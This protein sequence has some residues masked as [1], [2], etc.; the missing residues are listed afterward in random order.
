MVN[1]VSKEGLA[2]KFA[3]RHVNFLISQLNFQRHF[4]TLLLH[5]S[6]GRQTYT[7]HYRLLIQQL[8]W[9]KSTPTR[10]FNVFVTFVVCDEMSTLKIQVFWDKRCVVWRVVSDVS[11][12]PR[13]TVI[14]SRKNQSTRRH[15]SESLKVDQD[16][17]P[18]I[19]FCKNQHH[20]SPKIPTKIKVIILYPFVLNYN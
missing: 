14:T 6:D 19:K 4:R 10:S 7:S 16:R 12:S 18:N 1:S 8:L 9:H 5:V 20:Q 3:G 11:T 2:V 15:I 17:C 13:R